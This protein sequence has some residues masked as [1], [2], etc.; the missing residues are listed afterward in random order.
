MRLKPRSFASRLTRWIL[1]TFLLVM[2]VTSWLIYSVA[3]DAMSGEAAAHYQAVSDATGERIEKTLKAVETGLTNSVF[4]IEENLERPDQLYTTLKRLL[5]KSRHMSACE[6]AFEPDFYPKKGRWFEPYAAMM[7]DSTIIIKQIG[8]ADHDYHSQGWYIKTKERG[9]GGW[10]EP[11]IDET[12]T[13]DALCTFT[14]PIRNK[15]G[16]IVGVFGAHITLKW[17]AE[18]L[19]DIDYK[20]NHLLWVINDKDKSFASYS[21]I[22]DQKGRFIVHP[23]KKDLLSENWLKAAQI[24]T[25]SVSERVN[26]QMQAGESDF[27]EMTIDGIPSFIFYSPI[28]ITGWTMSIVVPSFTINFPGTILG[29]IIVVLMGFGLLAVFIVCRIIIRHATKPLVRLATSANEVAKGNFDTPLPVINHNDEIRRLR[30]SFQ[31]MQTSLSRYI[32]ELTATT[33]QKAAMESELTIAR[34]IQM[35]MLPKVFPPFPERTDI[36]LY[37]ALTPA[38]AVGGDLYD[39]YIRHERLFF[40]IGD[41]SGKGVPA[42]LVMAVSRT[43]FR[44]VASSEMS[45]EQ[46]VSAMNRTVSENNDSNMFVTLFVGVLDLNTGVLDYCNAGHDAPIMVPSNEPLPCDPNFPIGIVPDWKYSLQQAK[47][48]AGSTLFLFTDGLTEAQDASYAQFGLDRV[49]ATLRSSVAQ[50][51]LL[52][53]RMS[54]AV[55]DFVGEAEQSDDLTMLAIRYNGPMTNA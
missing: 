25:D 5:W 43:V 9:E 46:I 8:S 34:S 12:V 18:Q 41:V 42:S 48:K 17:I 29:V 16:E 28:K 22:T 24:V 21:F 27:G 45:P 11:Y 54:T 1:F 23:R 55:H 15:E 52:I 38:K 37:G 33:A 30:D 44:N 51:Q 35:S 6:I 19:H 31:E 3:K 20:D 50:P 47:L 26:R 36:D 40:C 10:S 39:F 32:S 53:N 4:E 14:L 7:A 2:A 49:L 13:K